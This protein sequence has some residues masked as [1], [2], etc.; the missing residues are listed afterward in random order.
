MKELTK[1]LEQQV[2]ESDASY[3]ETHEQV[4]RNMRYYTL[5]PLGNEVSGRSH[6]VSPDVHDLV[7]S[8]KALFKET[9]LSNRQTV[10]FKS[11]GLTPPGEAEAKT[12]Y[13]QRILEKNEKSKLFAAFW[14]DAFLAKRGVVLA[15]WIEDTNTVEFPVQGANEQQLMQM[16]GSQGQVIDM[17]TD[18]L[19]QQAVPSIGPQGAPVTQ[20]IYSG[21]VTVEV[22]DSYLR[23]SLCA[24][25][26]YFRDPLA[27]CIENAMWAT[28]QDEIPR[29]T[30]KREGYDHDVVDKL[31][32]DYRW[33]RADIDFARKAH[34]QSYTTGDRQSRIDDQETVT[35]FKTFTWINL[36]AMDVDIGRGEFGEG[37]EQSYP[38]E[39]RLY[40]IHWAN[41]EI[42]YWANGAPAVREVDEMPFFEWSELPISHADTGM[43]GADVVAHSQKTNSTLKRAIIDNANIR[44]NTRFEAVHDN[45]LN[46]R[47]LVD[48]SIGGVIFSEQ[49][50]SVAPLAA[51]DLSPLTFSAIQMLAQDTEA[52]SG[53]SSLAKGMNSD[54]LRYQNASDMVERLTNAAKTRPMASARDWAQTFLIP[55]AQHIVRIGMRFD[56]SQD[57]VESGGQ[58]IPV[59]PAQW[60]DEELAMEVAVAL[61][62][63]EGSDHAQKLMVMHQTMLSDPILSQLYG[64]KERHSLMDDVFDAMG[65]ADTQR[66]LMR[67]DSPEFQQQ[68]QQQQMMSQQQQQQQM[69]LMQLQIKNME[70]T[71]AQRWAE[72]NSRSIDRMED[73]MREDEKLEWEKHTDTEELRLEEE[74][75]RAVDVG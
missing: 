70:E 14:H 1:I 59:I 17:N 23:L 42:L 53:M 51:P 24:P 66:Y 71:T 9:F 19:Q 37:E 33:Q 21:T 26:R 68:Q 20:N 28:Y 12:A 2:Q 74:Q 11:T 25:E 39:I 61:T 52:R 46:P 62:P 30:L 31:D 6:Y 58:I 3:F 13:T 67:P 16:A 22:E 65:V 49:I 8:K 29:G 41:G 34:D 47:D 73:N 43:C 40:E 45:L 57:R 44:N 48:N 5:E 56:K 18:Q 10:R 50:G 75:A 69:M 27:D 63:D 54:A 72:I 55:L 60:Q 7:E 36:G 38:D 15:E 35:F 64:L 4:E 32:S